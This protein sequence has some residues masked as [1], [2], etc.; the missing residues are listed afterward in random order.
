MVQFYQLKKTNL[1]SGV[2]NVIKWVTDMTSSNTRMKDLYYFILFCIN[3]IFIAI[4]YKLI[5][6]N[7]N[8]FKSEQ[9]EFLIFIVITGFIGFLLVRSNKSRITSGAIWWKQLV[10]GF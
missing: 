6:I 9:K 7:S 10:Q 3:N 1:N 4:I 2:T 5:S 8:L